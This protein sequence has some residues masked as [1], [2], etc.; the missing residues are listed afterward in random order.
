M[1]SREPCSLP[2]AHVL[3]LEPG[4]HPMAP[5]CLEPDVL[6]CLLRVEIGGHTVP[7]AGKL[8]LG[9]SQ[10][11]DAPR[12]VGAARDVPWGE[13]LSFSH[14]CPL[15]EKKTTLLGQMMPV[16]LQRGRAHLC[17]P[18]FPVLSPVMP[19]DTVQPSSHPASPLVLPKSQS[20]CVWAEQGKEKTKWKGTKSYPHQAMYY[21][22]F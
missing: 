21:Y 20:A 8:S 16:W 18:G 10:G 15:L 6:Q 2:S 5:G 17:W 4:Q 11:L 3:F 9:V 13:T 14:C 19:R 7:T 1:S 12:D 22:G